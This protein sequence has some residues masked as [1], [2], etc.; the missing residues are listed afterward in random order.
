MKVINKFIGK[1]SLN[2]AMAVLAVT[3][4]G[5][6]VQSAGHLDRPYDWNV[7]IETKR[8]EHQF[9]YA[10]SQLKNVVKTK[11]D[12]Y[13]SGDQ[14]FDDRHP[15][16]DHKILYED[17]W[18]VSDRPLGLERRHEF[19]LDRGDG[20][21]IQVKHKEGEGSTREYKAAADAVLRVMLDSLVH[22][23]PVV[24][25]RLPDGQPY[26]EILD[27][28]RNKGAIDAPPHEEGTPFIS[29]DINIFVKEETGDRHATLYYPG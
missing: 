23:N 15:D 24:I 7:T 9:E 10:G 25:V 21:A 17:M 26:D 27:E 1:V 19:D 6:A 13:Y 20:I 12:Y 5:S 8:L 28:L 22:R 3:A 18:F 2:V 11:V 16:E 4:V 14:P 29:E